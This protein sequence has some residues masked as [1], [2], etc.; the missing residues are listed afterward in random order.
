MQRNLQEW[1]PQADACDREGSS[2]RKLNSSATLTRERGP[3]KVRSRYD[4]QP[5]AQVPE[6]Q[7]AGRVGPRPEQTPASQWNQ[8]NAAQTQGSKGP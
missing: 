3:E 6:A 5:P 1:Q 2:F 7:V 8:T 4:P